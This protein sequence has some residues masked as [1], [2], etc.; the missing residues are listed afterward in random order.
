MRS[1]LR[2][3]NN[4]LLALG[5]EKQADWCVVSLRHRKKL[6]DDENVCTI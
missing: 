2:R 4:L 6:L 1:T 3:T 5:Y